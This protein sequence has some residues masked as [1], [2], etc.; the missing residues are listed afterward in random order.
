MFEAVV[1][2]NAPTFN[3]EV[4][5]IDESLLSEGD[6]TV[7]IEY[8]TLNYKDA[9]AITNSAPI[10]HQWPMVAGIDGAGTVVDS[11]SPLW[12]AGDKIVLNGYGAG[13]THTGCLGQRARLKGEW[14]V[15]L[16]ER[17]STR[18]AMAVGTAGYTAMLSV[19][20]I[21]R[22]GV[23]PGDGEVLVTGASGGVGSMAIVLLAQLGYRVV[24]LTGKAGEATFLKSLG[25]ARILDRTE[26][27]APGKMLQKEQWVAAIDVVGSHTLANVCAQTHRGGIVT[28]CGFV[29]GIDLPLTMPPFMMRGVTLAGIDSVWAKMPLRELAWKRLADELDLSRLHALTREIELHAVPQEAAGLLRGQ[30]RG[31]IVVKT[32]K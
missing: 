21:E 18:D 24:A 9:L 7:D 25:A 5:A 32:S 2:R 28:A 15:R 23:R 27:M 1:L 14:L 31:R 19:L 10:V 12:N 16:P 29:Q 22:H 13:E 11:H 8:S 26:F 4:T 20:E 17:L 3:A 30:A 6:V